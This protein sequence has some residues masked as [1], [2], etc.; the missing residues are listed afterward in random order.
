M[1]CHNPGLNSL[2][3]IR[4][5]R[6]VYSRGREYD[7]AVLARFLF[8]EFV[9]EDGCSISNGLLSPR[10]SSPSPSSPSPSSRSS[11]SSALQSSSPSLSSSPSDSIP[12]VRSSLMLCW[13]CWTLLVPNCE[14]DRFS[15]SYLGGTPTM[16]TKNWSI[17]SWAP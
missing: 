1:R 5:V 10:L 2:K 14:K 3:E 6:F 8:G 9:A 15:E 13:W 11:S 16:L 7:L 17:S 12:S 4:E